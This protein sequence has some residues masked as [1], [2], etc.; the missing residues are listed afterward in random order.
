MV[1]AVEGFVGAS[2][3]LLVSRR[4]AAVISHPLAGTVARSGDR[5]ND[6]HLDDE[7]L[8]S[9]KE[10]EE[11]RLVV[12]A[13]AEALAALHHPSGPAVP[14]IVELRNVSH[15]GTR[16]EGQLHEGHRTTALGLAASLHPTPA[17]AG[18]PTQKAL[19][20]LKATEGF[21]RAA[22]PGRWDGWTA[23]ATATGPSASGR[24][25]LT[26]PGPGF[27]PVSEW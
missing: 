16:I 13:V 14:T 3:E 9:P 4:G 24:R 25:R 17:V 27:L 7:L 11:H 8:A 22:T 2:P 23:A 5:D 15:L 18:K 19:D 10:R 21:D 12:D 1:F 26:G 6:R 20:Y